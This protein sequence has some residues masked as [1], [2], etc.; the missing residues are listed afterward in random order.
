MYKQLTCGTILECHGIKGVV[1]FNDG[2]T[3]K[4]QWNKADELTFPGEQQ[5]DRNYKIVECTE[6][7][8][9][10]LRNWS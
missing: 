1:T 4:I 9:S 2:I 6:E 3:V 5:I 10:G 7:C 8:P